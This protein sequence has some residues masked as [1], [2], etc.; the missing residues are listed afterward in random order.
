VLKPNVDGRH[1]TQQVD[2]MGQ[3]KKYWQSVQLTLSPPG[4]RS[5][6]PVAG[7]REN[8]RH[9]PASNVVWHL[10]GGG[11]AAIAISRP[12]AG[13]PRLGGGTA[14]FRGGAFLAAVAFFL[15]AVFLAVDLGRCFFAALG[16]CFFAGEIFRFFAMVW[17]P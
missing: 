10:Y 12:A 17:L 1:Q 14:F 3:S 16:F 5:Y 11:A 4:G 8:R 2:R 6:C 7:L 13:A 9:T 15:R